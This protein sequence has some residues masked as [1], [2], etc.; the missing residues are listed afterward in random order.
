MTRTAEVVLERGELPIL[1]NARDVATALRDACASERTA[2]CALDGWRAIQDFRFIDDLIEVVEGGTPADDLRRSAASEL[3][4]ARST[5]RARKLDTLGHIAQAVVDGVVDEVQRADHEAVVAQM[6]TDQMLMVRQSL[7][8]LDSVIREVND[9]RSSHLQHLRSRWESQREGLRRLPDCDVSVD[10][11]SY[12]ER[13]LAGGDSR[14]VEECLA[15]IDQVLGEGVPLDAAVFAGTEDVDYLKAYLE[16]Y[17]KLSSASVIGQRQSGEDPATDGAWNAWNRLRRPAAITAQMAGRHILTV[18]RYLGV[19]TGRSEQANVHRSEP[20][21]GWLHASVTD[22]PRPGVPGV[23]HFGYNARG[24]YAVLCTW[25]MPS[26]PTLAQRVRDGARSASDLLVFHLAPLTIAERFELGRVAQERS[27]AVAVLDESLLLYLGQLPTDRLRA[28]LHCA[29]PFAPANPYR[30]FAFG[31]VP[32]EMFYGREEHA[33]QLRDDGGRCIVYGGRQLGKSALLRR[34]QQLYHDPT[35][36][37]YGWVGSISSVGDPQSGEG[38]DAVWPK[39]HD[40]M[41]TLGILR[42]GTA[43]RPSVIADQIRKALD[44]KG[45]DAHNHDR[46]VLIMLDEA[47]HFLEADRKQN[48]H[49]VSMIRDLMSETG[50]RFKVVFAGTHDVQRFAATPNHPLAHFGASL[51]VEVGPLEPEPAARLVREPLAALGYRFDEEG[52][53]LSI[54]SYTNYHAGLI[55]LFCQHVYEHLHRRAPVRSPLRVVRR[56]DV[57]AIYRRQEV[58]ES[59]ADR[60]NLTLQ[61]DDRYEL[62]ACAMIADQLQ[63]HDGWGRSYDTSQL[64]D[65]AIQWWP[66]GFAKVPDDEMRALLRE[67]RGLGLLVVG[68]DGRYRLRSPNLVRLVGTGAML[69]ARLR[70]IE[71]LPE[72]IRREDQYLHTAIEKGSRFVWSPL[73]QRQEAELVAGPA[74]I[75]V[76]AASEALGLGQLEAAMQALLPRDAVTSRL[77]EYVR[78]PPA[79]RGAAPVRAWLRDYMGRRQRYTQVHIGTVHHEVDPNLHDLIAAATTFRRERRDSRNRIAVAVILGPTAARAMFTDRALK[80]AVQRADVLLHPGLWQSEGIRMRVQLQIGENYGAGPVSG[81]LTTATGG[82][83]ILLDELF[84]RCPVGEDPRPV[85]TELRSE[86]A[87]SSTEL[88]RRF[89]AALGIDEGGPEANILRYLA[90]WYPEPVPR[91]MMQP[92]LAKQGVELTDSELDSLLDYLLAL[93][94]ARQSSEGLVIDP[95]VA[96]AALARGPK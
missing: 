91:D 70:R 6:D 22:D 82:W 57:E 20:E 31:D 39:I 37:Q 92:D 75:S 96:G 79:I 55:Q 42:A 35:A 89:W 8:R 36:G 65:F 48:F 43:G 34:T 63:E 38:A 87:D 54:L 90:A 64:L 93:S 58:R 72:P 53:V 84:D 21:Q 15:H 24:R 33:R 45:V 69:D 68:Q 94:C 49:E 1:R 86:L 80:L 73:T 85:A 32:P 12:I 3:E 28:F 14:L 5:L 27:H 23:P 19:T 95:V 83:P 10:A 76:V 4:G 78:M 41:V 7:E 9:A 56:A 66:N 61:L 18:C 81:A 67:M 11:H 50:R 62:I 2:Q 74:T 25:P 59:I 71:K 51:P 77:A 17:D 29:L 88:H 52:T 30:P 13:R 26:G 60:F 40:G 44:P 16:A 46:R 47:D